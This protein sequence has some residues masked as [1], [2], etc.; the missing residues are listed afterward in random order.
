LTDG[1][2]LRRRA[3]ELGVETSYRDV[4]GRLHRAG[5]AT[6]RT[7]VDVLEADAAAGSSRHLEPVLVA[8]AGPLTVDGV[9]D[10]QLTLAD[11]TRVGLHQDAATLELPG[12]LPIGC[13][14][15]EGSFNGREEITT[16]VVPPPTMPRDHSLTGGLGLFVPAYALWEHATPLPSFAHLAALAGR[17]PRDGVDVVSTLPLYAAFFDAPFDPSPY[18]PMSRLHWNE[19]YIDDAALP[20]APEP[21][22]TGLIDWRSLARRRRLQ[23]LDLGGDAD[24]SLL[25]AVAQFVATRPDVADFA[26]YRAAHPEPADAGRPAAIVRRSHELAQ[27]LAHGQLAGVEGAGTAVLALDLPIGSHPDGYETWAHGPLFAPAMAVGAPPDEFFADGQN[28]GF[29]PPLP[30]AGRRS[31]HELWRRLVAR[32]GEHASMLRIDHVMGVQRLWWIPDGATATD[33]VYVR[34]PRDE[35][36]AVIAAQAAVTDTTVV[37]ENLG[38]VPPEITEAMD[39]WDM[40]GMYEEQLLLLRPD[41]HLV[42]LDPIP[43]RSVAGI[44]THDMPAFAAVVADDAACGVE[45]YRRL[46]EVALRRPVGAGASELLE[47]AL[48]RLAVSD[49][50]L[51]LAD[52][53]DLVGETEPHNVPGQVLPTTWRRRL[54]A[55]TSEVLAIADVR[56]RLDLLASR[57]GRTR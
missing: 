46:V 1:D 7:V 14:R 9:T 20:A 4:A 47:A 24:P 8:P 19:V 32:A 39:R 15:L 34:Y 53:D 30:A 51:V 33:G 48:E 55:P 22:P 40:L 12:D 41:H 50:Y 29:P 2:G 13:H 27:H 57:R 10:L 45:R 35:V 49:A 21:R 36:L 37:G 11:G 3:T 6:L 31:G 43:A 18:A 23:L 26:R 42:D 25:A 56:R 38:T 5:E 44:R 52:L 28:W 16:V 54:R 17:L